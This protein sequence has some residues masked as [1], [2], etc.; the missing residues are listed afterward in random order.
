[1]KMHIYFTAGTVI[2]GYHVYKE[3]WES[4][5]GEMLDCSVEDTNRYDCNAVAVVKSQTIVGHVPK[6]ISLICKLFL[7][8]SGF[9]LCEVIGRRQYSSDLPQGGLEVLCQLNFKGMSEK[10]LKL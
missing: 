2:R 9:I 3:I 1:M 6:N 5:I 7:R 8:R 10:R 4:S